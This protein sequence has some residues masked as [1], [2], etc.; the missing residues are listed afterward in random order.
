MCKS[1]N[2]KSPKLFS[3]FF[4]KNIKQNK[5]Q[6]DRVKVLFN[7]ILNILFNLMDLKKV[8]VIKE[9]AIVIQ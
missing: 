8:V 5:I 6:R 3:N 9:R 1:P 7:R 4:K 2:Y